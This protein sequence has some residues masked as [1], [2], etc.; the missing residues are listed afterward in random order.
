MRFITA[1]YIFPVSSSPIKNGFVV[2]DDDGA[3]VTVSP[4]NH[5]P[6]IPHKSA[7]ESFRGIICPGFINAHCHLELSHLKNKLSP[8]KGLP[9]F[10]K[11]VAMNRKSS[12]E[13][14]KKAIVQAEDEMIAGG[15]VA[16]GDIS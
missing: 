8:G 4:A 14:I 1:D 15:I 3:V 13:E 5:P 16:V 11:E 7:L 12:E 6:M 2:T 10:I 9:H